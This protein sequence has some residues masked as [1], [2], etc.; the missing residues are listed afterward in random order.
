LGNGRVELRIFVLIHGDGIERHFHVRGDALVFHAPF[1][2]RREEAKERTS[3]VPDVASIISTKPT[4]S[5][6]STL[7]PAMPMMMPA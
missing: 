3:G 6:V 5:T 2:V 7:T 1:T 4:I